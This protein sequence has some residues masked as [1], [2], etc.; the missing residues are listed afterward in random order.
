MSH[1]TCTESRR[2]RPRP[3]SHRAPPPTGAACERCSAPR[4]RPSLSSWIRR[5]WR[6]RRGKARRRGRERPR[7]SRLWCA[8]SSAAADSREKSGETLQHT[9]RSHLASALRVE[10]PQ[11]TSCVSSPEYFTSS[12]FFR[13]E[14]DEFFTAAETGGSKRNALSVFRIA[15]KLLFI[16]NKDDKLVGMSATPSGGGWFLSSGS[17]LLPLAVLVVTD[18]LFSPQRFEKLCRMIL[19]SMEAENEP[20]VSMKEAQDR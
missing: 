5:V 13:K 9:C 17:A 7:R 20:K 16:F 1:G 3:P 14:V 19:S 2:E 10:T 15:R 8:G 18:L 6:G 12:V 4:R 11:H